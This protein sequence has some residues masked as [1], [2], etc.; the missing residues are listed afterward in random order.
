MGIEQKIMRDLETLGLPLDFNLKMKGYSKCYYGRYDPRTE[1]ITLYPLDEDKKS[2]MDYDTIIKTAIH[3]CIH[4]YQWKHDKSFKRVRG[5]MH[6]AKFKKMERDY[7]QSAYEKGVI[8]DV[9]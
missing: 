2:Y 8:T 7:F 9:N 3:E 5:V 6:D 1:V 4:H